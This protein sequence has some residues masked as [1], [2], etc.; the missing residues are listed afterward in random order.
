MT[1]A[2]LTKNIQFTVDQRGQV[3]AVVL[4]PALWNRI[5]TALE[6]AEDWALIQALRDRLAQGPVAA[7]ALPW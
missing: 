2:E 3:T 4:D 6:D 1:V 7:G 5:L